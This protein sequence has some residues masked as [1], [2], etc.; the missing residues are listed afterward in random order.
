MKRADGVIF[1]TNYAARIIQRATGKLRNF[2]VIPHGVGEEFKQTTHF[3]AWAEEPDRIIRCL[4]VSNTEMYKHQWV[5]VRAIGKLRRRG[6]N[7]SLLLAGGGSGREQRLLDE[8]L[9]RT[10]QQGDCIESIGFVQHEN[11]PILLSKADLFIFASSCENMP[12]TLLE[13]MASGLPIACSDRG[14]MPEILEDGIFPILRTLTP[15]RRPQRHYF[16]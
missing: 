12:I 13:A 9:F 7:V 2:S 8:E 5:V 1:L 10:D 3:G 6:H 16:K 4:Y 14:P 15:S 11:M